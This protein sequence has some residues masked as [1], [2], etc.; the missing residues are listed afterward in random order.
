MT[1]VLLTFSVLF[2]HWVA[3]F[4]L[5]THWQASNKSKNWDALTR[6]VATYSVAVTAL[7]CWQFP[8]VYDIP[9]F[10]VVTFAAH[11]LTDAV[12]SR[13]TSKLY[14][15][16]DYHNFFVVVGFD[17][18]LHYAQLLLTIYWLPALRIH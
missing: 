16:G 11:F 6:H 10:F 14:A 18:L 1:Q 7:L 15:K 2:A 8:V 12:T 5:Q 4:V 17:Q 9:I 3:D 13:I